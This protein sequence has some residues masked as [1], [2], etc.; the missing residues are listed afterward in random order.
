VRKKEL[1]LHTAQQPGDGAGGPV[2]KKN[3]HQVGE[4]SP[5]RRG[6]KIERGGVQQ[7]R[8]AKRKVG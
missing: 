3:K 8:D 5:T 2:P 4:K 6:G 1:A 7:A